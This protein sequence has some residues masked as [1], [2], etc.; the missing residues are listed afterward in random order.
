MAG[1]RA[2]GLTNGYLPVAAFEHFEAT[3]IGVID[4]DGTPDVIVPYRAER[5]GVA[6]DG[7]LLVRLHGE[8]LAIVHLAGGLRDL[9]SDRLEGLWGE[10]AEVIAAHS[11]RYRCD[12][13]ERAG[14]DRF[15]GEHPATAQCSGARFQTACSTASV[16]IPTGGRPGQLERCLR[17]MLALRQA[18]V[19]YLVVDNR[20]DLDGSRA[21]VEALAEDGLDV[22]YVAEPR[23]GSSVARNRGLVETDAELVAF[24][25]DD[26]VVDADWLNWLLSPFADPRVTV[27]TGMV[28]PLALESEAQKR[29]EQ[30]AGFSKGVTSRTYDLEAAKAGERVLYPYWGGVFGSGNSM[31][32]R[33]SDLVAAG[34]FDPALGAGSP[35]LA[36]ADIEAFS[37]AIVRGGRLVYEPRALCWHEHR[38][39]EEALRRQI[40]NY[41]AGFTAIMTKYL[42][43]D[44]RFVRAVARSVPVAIEARRTNHGATGGSARLPASYARLARRGMVRGPWLYA[45]SRRWARQLHLEE[46]ITE[47]SGAPSAVVAPTA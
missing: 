3:E 44:R 15:R 24:T 17:S 29:F 40:F 43:H 34:G 13:G 21:V 23:P 7:L 47:S 27:V 36:G 39:S 42:L 2:A 20:P 9:S 10:L 18:H 25:D 41:G 38:A 4:L 31:A 26:V 45:R 5:S 32:F 14:H 22:R 30:Y 8:P 35:A 33:R 46:V 37:A 16:I 11:L 19:D 12:A 6:R 1:Y 28:L